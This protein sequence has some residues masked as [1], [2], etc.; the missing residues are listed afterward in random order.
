M[1]DSFFGHLVR[2]RDALADDAAAI[3]AV[4]VASWRAA[5]VGLLPDIVLDGL[6]VAQRAR[7]WRHVVAP[8]SGDRVVVAESDGQLLGF[9]QVGPATDADAGPTTGQLATLYVRPEA[10]GS[11][12]G[13]LVHDAGLDR[14]AG[15]GCDRAVLWMLSTNAR[16]AQFYEREG[17]LR[18]EKIRV[19]Q[20]GGAVVIDHRYTRALLDC[21]A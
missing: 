10:W 4:H 2:V 5:Y 12:V 11:G 19:Q 13:T 6:S 17:W 1:T 18:E 15:D 16:A 8:D 20:F 14:L 21:T 7:H 3:A 9:A